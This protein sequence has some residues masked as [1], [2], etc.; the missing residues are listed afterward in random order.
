MR[1]KS[2]IGAFIFFVIASSFALIFFVQ[3]DRFG[4][5]ASKVISDLGRRKAQAE[6]S[7]KN[8]S[9]SLF[10]PGV[11]LNQVKI[12]KKMADNED[13]K[14][15]FGKLGFYVGLVELEEKKISLGRITISDSTVDYSYPKKEEELEK[16]DQKIID[17]VFKRSNQLPIR[18]DTVTIENLKVFANYDVLEVKKLKLLKRRENYLV[19]FHV[20][21]LRPIQ[22][23]NISIDEIWG[24]AE[25]GR[26]N[27]VI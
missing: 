18:F 2:I 4:L 21:N 27:Y 11:E 22:D 8:I 10:P 9:I 23:K 25:I 1:F 19:R 12:S 7:F 17:E 16:I 3:T 15:E 24:D 26:K 14:S 13:F 5:V 20:A 6:I